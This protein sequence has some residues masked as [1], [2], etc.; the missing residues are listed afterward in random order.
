M[1]L[2]MTTKDRKK[3][4]PIAFKNLA[5]SYKY[6]RAC[7]LEE[8]EIEIF[9]NREKHYFCNTAHHDVY[10]KRERNKVSGLEARVRRIEKILEINKKKG[11]LKGSGPEK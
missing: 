1:S 5:A 9:T 2:I 4:K 3:L 11:P 6:H 7:K 10:W 8:C